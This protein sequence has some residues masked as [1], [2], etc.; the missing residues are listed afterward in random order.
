LNKRTEILETAATLVN[1]DRAR[2]YGTP[3]ANFGRIAAGWSVILDHDVSAEQVA[4]CMAWLK[5]A[6]LVN[7][8]HSDSYVDAAAYMALAAEL[9]E[10]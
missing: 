4:L 2:D 6:R 10:C 9:S 1:G 5:I 8:P 3:K 7:G